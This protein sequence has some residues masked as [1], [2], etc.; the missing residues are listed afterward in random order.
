M[1]RSAMAV[2]GCSGAY[3]MRANVERC[4]QNAFATSAE[5]GGFAGASCRCRGECNAVWT[6]LK[7]SWDL[8]IRF[9]VARDA[10]W[11]SKIRSSVYDA[12]RTSLSL[13]T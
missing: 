10:T 4:G 1:M 5:S 3:K 11:Q 2:E 7:R 8:G 13:S 12:K 9:R 6:E